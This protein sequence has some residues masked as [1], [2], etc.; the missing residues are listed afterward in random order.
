LFNIPGLWLDDVIY[1]QGNNSTVEI[2][3]AIFRILADY[4]LQLQ[5]TLYLPYNNVCVFNMQYS[6]NCPE[7][8]LQCIYGKQS[9]AMNNIVCI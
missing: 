3:W 6:K 2:S 5:Y 8:L 9:W 7:L 4:R 1:F